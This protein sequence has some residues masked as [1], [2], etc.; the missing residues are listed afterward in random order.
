M[1][2]QTPP[3]GRPQKIVH[4]LSMDSEIA[5]PPKQ[6]KKGEGE[7]SSEEDANNSRKVADLIKKIEGSQE[8]KRKYHQTKISFQKVSM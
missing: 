4:M 8:G 7:T 3:K 6:K 2:S 1:G 5:S